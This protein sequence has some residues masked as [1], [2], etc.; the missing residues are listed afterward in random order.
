MM[1]HRRRLMLAAALLPAT[2]V[3]TKLTPAEAAYPQIGFTK[4]PPIV[5][6]ATGVDIVNN[7]QAATGA[8][9]IDNAMPVSPLF[10]VE[11]WA[12]DRVR[13]NGTPPN[14]VRVLIEE[15]S[16]TQ[17][18]LPNEGGI[19]AQFLNLQIMRYDVAMA[20][21]VSI[22]DGD[23]NQ[24][25]FASGKASQTATIGSKD[26]AER[27][28]EILFRLVETTANDLDRQL[29]RNIRQYLMAYIL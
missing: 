6:A 2:A 23:R 14:R 11:R 27:R 7:V 21:S 8:P 12:A 1:L 13:A 20:V 16:A 17:T 9:N 25:G 4:E 24:L 19:T 3:L 28:D 18:N 29:D 26:S 10:A 15:A 22:F 5:F